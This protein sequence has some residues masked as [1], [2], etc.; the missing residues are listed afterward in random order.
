MALLNGADT[1]SLSST[2]NT[3]FQTL[4]GLNATANPSE[5]LCQKY[6]AP[7]IGPSASLPSIFSVLTANPKNP[8]PAEKSKTLPL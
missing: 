8:C 7:N 1:Y 4:T 5:T 3:A 6:T 2:Y